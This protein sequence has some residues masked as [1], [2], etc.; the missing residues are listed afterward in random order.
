MEP[1]IVC[2]NCHHPVRSAPYLTS[3]L[4]Y[5]RGEI[6]YV[7]SETRDRA[8]V[9]HGPRAFALPR[10]RISWPDEPRA[11]LV[12]PPENRAFRRRRRTSTST[13]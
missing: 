6:A 8:C 3:P 10:E 4:A 13:P 12:T 1:Q 7:H 5:A 9:A 2:R 11:V